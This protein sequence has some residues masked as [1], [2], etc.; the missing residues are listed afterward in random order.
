MLLTSH[1]KD[2]KVEAGTIISD[3]I[4]GHTAVTATVCY[5]HT[6]YL[7]NRLDK[8]EASFSYQFLVDRDPG[9]GGV[10]KDSLVV[11]LDPGDG[12]CALRVGHTCDEHGIISFHSGILRGYHNGHVKICKKEGTT[13]KCFLSKV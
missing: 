6:A 4:A 5:L 2:G 1:R 7:Q 12:R 8:D 3:S 11:I 10:V 9:T 13:D